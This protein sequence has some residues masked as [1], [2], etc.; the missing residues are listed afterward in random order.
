MIETGK[1]RGAGPDDHGLP[2]HLFLATDLQWMQ[3]ARKPNPNEIME[4]LM[5]PLGEFSKV[6]K[7]GLFVEES[8]VVCAY[9]ALIELEHLQW[10]K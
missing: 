7:S 4:T 6:L 5:V 1:Y 9:K 8:A 3:D 10:S 2:A